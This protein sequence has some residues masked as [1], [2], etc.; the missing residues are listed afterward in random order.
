[1]KKRPT[2]VDLFSLAHSSHPPADDRIT[3]SIEHLTTEV[4]FIQ[5]ESS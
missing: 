3:H 2:L 4:K 5:L 1:M